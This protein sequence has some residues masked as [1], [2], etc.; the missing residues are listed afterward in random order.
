M[1]YAGQDT[2][3]IN[4]VFFILI[5]LGANFHFFECVD[6]II[7][8]TPDFVNARVCAIAELLQ[9][10]EISELCVLFVLHL[11]RLTKAWVTGP[12]LTLNWC[13][14]TATDRRTV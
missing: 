10:H 12:N 11:V 3:L 6:L 9:D 4:C 7:L 14:K 5:R 1:I 13:L 2:H 8:Y